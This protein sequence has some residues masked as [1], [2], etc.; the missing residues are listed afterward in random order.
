MTGAYKRS[1][2]PAEQKRF[3]AL[4]WEFRRPP[5]TLSPERQQAL[6]AL[7]A[8]VPALE[9]LYWFRW[10][11]TNIFDTAPDRPSAAARIEELREIAQQT[12]FAE[13]LEK[14]FGT[15]DR[16]Q[17]GILAYFDARQTSG[18]VEGINNKAR[19][20][21][22]RAYGLKSPETLWTRLLLDL[23]RAADVVVHTVQRMHDLMRAIKHKFCGYY[24]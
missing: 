2:S 22:K 18:V 15:Y 23:N 24:T 4:L 17:E 20:I 10:E 6:E 9:Y 7:F 3:R 19:V 14:F 8:E 1:L 12:E 13:G 16:W 5:G 11:I 21:T